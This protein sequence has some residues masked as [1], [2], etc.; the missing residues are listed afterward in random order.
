MPPLNSIDQ[1][2]P[3]TSN[4]IGWLFTWSWQVFV[5]LGVAW[6]A[7]RLDRSKSATI[8]YR[9]WLVGVLAAALLPLLTL[10]SHSL[11][12]PT[13]IA[14][15]LLPAI[16]DGDL[17]ALGRIETAPP[18]YPWSSLIWPILFSLWVAGMVI[19]FVRLGNSLWKLRKI[20]SR[21][22]A[23]SIAELDCSYYDLL[24]VDTGRVTIT[25]SSDIQSPGLA[26]LFRPVILLPSDIVSWT[27]PEERT[28]ILRHEFAHVK[29]HDHLASLFQSILRALLFFHPMLRHACNQLSLERELACDDYVLHLGTEPNAYAES[30]LKAAERSF[31]TDVVHQTASFASRMKLERRIDM[32]LDTNRVRWPLKQ[33]QFLLVPVMLIAIITWL[34]IPA[35]SGKHAFQVEDSHSQSNQSVS[36]PSSV[37]RK[38]GSIP[39]VDTST[40]WVDIVK[41]GYWRQMVRGIGVLRPTGDGR[42]KAEIDIPEPQ[43][44]DIEPGQTASIDTRNGIIAGKVIGMNPSVTNGRLTVDIFLEGDL[45]KDLSP[46]LAVDGTIEVGHLDDVLYV[47][48]PVHA[49]PDSVSSVFRIDADGKT[50][51]RVQVR[52][53]KMSVN[54]VEIQDG[55]DVGDKVILSDMSKFDG[56]DKVRLKD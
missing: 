10:I 8:R 51:T 12:L 19:S 27:I 5:L 44:K 55:L 34:V 52:F 56:V 16:D 25:L 26:G 7:I 22:R 1:I 23:V 14:P 28:S 15:A 33:W 42:F 18:D 30:I 24:A 48:R 35:A 46:G 40:F 32:I 38:S 50:A 20:E 29:R 2:I 9:I 54:T 37:S 3:F 36:A 53:G 45:P 49:Q 6:V 31:L 17:A 43:A 21:A 11:R 41:R 4:V 47:G 39:D 13:V